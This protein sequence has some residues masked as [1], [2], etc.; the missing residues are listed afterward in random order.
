MR[1]SCISHDIQGRRGIIGDLTAGDL[2]VVNMRSPDDCTDDANRKCRWRAQEHQWMT[3]LELVRA[4][5][6]LAIGK[7]PTVVSDYMDII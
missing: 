5:R 6:A 3:Y 4:E 2:T 7:R 1:R